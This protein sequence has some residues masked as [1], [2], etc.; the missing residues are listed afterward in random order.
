LPVLV[1]KLLVLHD[2]FVL[3]DMNANDAWSAINMIRRRI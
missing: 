2:T 3:M 1:F